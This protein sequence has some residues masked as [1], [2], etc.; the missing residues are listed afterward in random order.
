MFM[1]QLT[2]TTNLFKVSILPYAERHFIKRFAKDY[3]GQQ[4]ELTRR[5]IIAD[6]ERIGIST[7]PLQRSN[8][9]DELSW[10]EKKWL[11]KYDFKIAG[12]HTSTKTSGN[13]VIGVLN[14]KTY[15]IDLFLV[16]GKTDL[17]KNINETDYIFTVYKSLD[18][19]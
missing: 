8:Q 2:S 18:M 17:P 9:I 14:S 7:N 6:L 5:S 13:R 16:Y 19:V 12:S 15:S 1:H 11:F 10:A 4:W 3:K